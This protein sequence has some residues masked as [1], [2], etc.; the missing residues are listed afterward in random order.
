MPE[1]LLRIM[2]AWFVMMI[3]ASQSFQGNACNAASGVYFERI[4]GQKVL[5]QVNKDYLEHLPIEVKQG[6]AAAGA[7]Y[8]QQLR[9]V[10]HH[11]L[12]V[13]IGF[14]REP[15]LNETVVTNSIKYELSFP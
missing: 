4:Q 15:D 2:D 5:D 1:K 11:G 6:G 7:Y 12:V 8:A 9:F 3:C 13:G 14:K 10:L